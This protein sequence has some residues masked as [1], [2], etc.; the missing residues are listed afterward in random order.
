MLPCVRG[1]IAD[2]RSPH[3]ADATRCRIRIA[4]PVDRAER[5]AR[6]VP[7]PRRPTDFP[8]VGRDEL[9][10]DAGGCRGI[11]AGGR[12]SEDS[13]V[14]RS[15]HP[16]AGTGRHGH[17]DWMVTDRCL[18][19]GGD[20]LI[21]RLDVAGSTPVARSWITWM[22]NRAGGDHGSTSLTST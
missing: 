20:L 13:G 1:I 9:R 19:E 22:I 15:A 5:F 6:V 16:P 21:P 12:I 11:P 10:K 18:V 8:S 7:R 17:G 4:A 2:A 14:M 3:S